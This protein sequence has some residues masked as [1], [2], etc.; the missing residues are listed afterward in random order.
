MLPLYFP[1]PRKTPELIKE[2]EAL[3]STPSGDAATRQT[4]SE[5]PAEV[6]DVQ[7]AKKLVELDKQKAEQ[8]LEQTRK[9]VSELTWD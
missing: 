9:W 7:S 8:L 3:Q 2:L 4:I 6:S 5:F 1:P